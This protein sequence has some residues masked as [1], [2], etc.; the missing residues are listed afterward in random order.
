MASRRRDVYISGPLF[1]APERAYLEVI[2]KACQDRSYS[3]YLPHRDAG[4][5]KARGSLRRKFF[6]ADIRM[7][8]NSRMVVAVLN[9]AEV[10]AGTAWEVGFAF[11]QKKPIVGIRED[12]RM[13]EI[14]LMLTG[15]LELVSSIQALGRRLDTILRRR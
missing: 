11:A 3:T 5:A 1:T 8:R 14:N 4:Y 13:H 2:D 15:S 6:L 12:L 10:D 9:G 7:L